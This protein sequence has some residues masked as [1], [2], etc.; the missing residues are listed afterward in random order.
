MPRAAAPPLCEPLWLASLQRTLVLKENMYKGSKRMYISVMDGTHREFGPVLLS[1]LPD[2]RLEDLQEKLPFVYERLQELTADFRSALLGTMADTISPSVRPNPELSLLGDVLDGSR[3]AQPPEFF[4]HS[5]DSVRDDYKSRHL[6]SRNGRVRDTSYDEA[7]QKLEEMGLEAEAWLSEVR[8][9]IVQ[10]DIILANVPEEHA[11]AARALQEALIEL[12]GEADDEHA[13]AEEPAA[14]EACEPVQE[15]IAAAFF[16]SVREELAWSAES[17][18]LPSPPLAVL[19]ASYRGCAGGLLLTASQLLWV[20][21]GTLMHPP[22]R[23]PLPPPRLLTLRPR[24]PP[25]PPV[26]PCSA[27]PVSHGSHAYPP[28]PPPSP[29][30]HPPL[31]AVSAFSVP[32]AWAPG[33]PRQPPSPPPPPPL[34]LPVSAR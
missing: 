13:D 10:A 25:S 21:M 5:K 23:Q 4:M 9:I 27:S 8:R 32:S 7:V 31:P 34:P 15:A 33:P 30:S 24:R 16:E 17:G 18:T 11:H 2:A 20:P 1:E 29:R 19:K 12:M 22:P 28:L 14:C 3:A 6:G 26:P